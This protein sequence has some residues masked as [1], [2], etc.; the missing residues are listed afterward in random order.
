M[1]D[2]NRNSDPL[3]AIIQSVVAERQRRADEHAALRASD[4]Y[5]AALHQID[6]YILDYGLGINAMAPAAQVRAQPCIARF[7][8]KRFAWL[9]LSERRRSTSAAT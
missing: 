6:R 3:A 8:P 4:G 2:H 1:Y 5:K 7:C 9:L